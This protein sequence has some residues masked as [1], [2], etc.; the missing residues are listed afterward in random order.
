MCTE[1]MNS[2]DA[3]HSYVASLPRTGTTLDRID[4]N[5]NYEPGNVRWA[6]HKQQANNTRSNHTL[7]FNGRSMKIAQWS[8]EIGISAAA[9]HAR[10]GRLGWSVE[11][12]LT[13]P[14][15]PDKRRIEV[16][17][18]QTLGVEFLEV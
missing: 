3:F 6:T 13:E 11:R 17:A 8:D 7:D 16:H 1:W 9:I 10:V 5:G 15:K 12:A 4:T 14:P 2:F 18:V